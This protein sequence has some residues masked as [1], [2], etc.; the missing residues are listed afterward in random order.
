MYSWHL[1]LRDYV[2][3]RG[4][5]SLESVL[6]ERDHCILTYEVLASA[7]RYSGPSILRPPMGPRTSGLTLQF[8]LK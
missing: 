4:V 8:V 1:L 7:G 3:S 5:S 6:Y 2:L